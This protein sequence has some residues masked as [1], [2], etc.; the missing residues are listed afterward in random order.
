MKLIVY[1][2]DGTIY[3]GDSTVDFLKFLIN[4]KKKLIIYFPKFVFSYIKYKFKLISK[5][6]LKESIFSIF[7]YFD[8]IDE[9][10][11]EFWK[12]KEK[13]LKPFFR[14]K[15][16]HKNDVIAT[17]SPEFLIKPIAD[18][19]KIKKLFGS[20]VD[21]KTGKY[22]GLNCHGQEKIKRIQNMYPKDIIYEMYSDDVIADRPLLEL[23]QKSYIVK[24]NK[25]I[26]YDNN[27]NINK[28][29]KLLKLNK[30]IINYLIIGV[31]TTLVNIITKYALL[32]TIFDAKDPKQ[33]QLVVIISWVVAVLF[34]YITNRKIVFKSKNSSVLKEFVKFIEAR[35][36]TLIVEMLFMYIFV[37]LL[38][39]DTDLLV[40]ILSVISQFIV[41]VLNYIF[42]KIFVFK[43]K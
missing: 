30:Q 41:I 19:Y 23:S 36:L 11:I 28:R 43:T 15:K 21:K 29:K 12:R 34:A 2:F 39:L 33:L 20:I 16:N 38:K 10:L 1:D 9:L 14:N 42:S 27:V 22:L 31:L 18:K 17:A 35:I 40:A 4:K 5:E 24:K 8:N 7:R 37:T 26:L 6:K 13:K 25:I 3:D 32:F